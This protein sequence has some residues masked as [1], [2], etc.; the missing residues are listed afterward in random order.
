MPLRSYSRLLPL[1]KSWLHSLC[2]ISPFLGLNPCLFIKTNHV[3]SFTHCFYLVV[4]FLLVFRAW[5]EP[6]AL[7]SGVWVVLLFKKRYWLGAEIASTIPRLTAT[8]AKSQAL[9]WLIGPNCWG[10]SQANASN[11]V[12]WVAVNLTGARL[13]FAAQ[14]LL[15]R[16]PQIP[17]A[18]SWHLNCSQPRHLC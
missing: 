6:I 3:D 8:S 13:R 4:K 18:G 9:Q 12:T 5:V 16:K 11:C 10:D 1:N 17:I 2:R 7:L 14:H 15:N